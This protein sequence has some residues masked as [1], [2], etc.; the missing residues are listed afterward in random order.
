VLTAVRECVGSIGLAINL[1]L[2]YWL[3]DVAWTFVQTGGAPSLLVA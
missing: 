1:Q 2:D 3:A